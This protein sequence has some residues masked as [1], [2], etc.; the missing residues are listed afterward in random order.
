MNWNDAILFCNWLL[1][2][3][4]GLHACYSRS[5]AEEPELPHNTAGKWIWVTEANGYRLPTAAEWEHAFRA[6]T[7]TDFSFGSDEELLQRYAVCCANRPDVTGSRLPNAWGLFD[8]HGNVFE[9]CYHASD[10]NP[11]RKKEPAVV[12]PRGRGKG[13]FRVTRGGSF[14]SASEHAKSSY[15]SSTMLNMRFHASGSR[16]V[17]NFP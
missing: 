10:G 7:V 12:D 1:S 14:V 3:R 2:R 17:R 11:F 6:G 9:L 5:N 16:I 15:Q 4:E 8:V 13:H